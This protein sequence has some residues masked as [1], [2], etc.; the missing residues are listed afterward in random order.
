M[1]LI[2][3]TGQFERDYKRMARRGLAMDKLKSIMRLLAEGTKL[4]PR[5]RDDKLT[6]SYAGRREC[7]IEPDWL[8]IYVPA[9]TEIIFERTGAH[10]DL[11]E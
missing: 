1:R 7:H 11:F 2:K 8:L 10:A 9:D 3:T 4:D 6:G 5:H